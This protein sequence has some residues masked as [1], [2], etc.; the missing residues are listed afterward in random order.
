MSDNISQKDDLLFNDDFIFT[1]NLGWK[2]ID[3]YGDEVDAMIIVLDANMGY[4]IF[5]LGEYCELIDWIIDREEALEY[6]VDLCRKEI[7]SHEFGE[8]T[9]D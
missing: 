4:N 9:K 5:R 8:M 7:S 2:E 6:A 3:E 1:K